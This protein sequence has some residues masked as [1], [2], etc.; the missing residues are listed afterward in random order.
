MSGASQ[1]ELQEDIGTVK[2]DIQQ[3]KQDLRAAKATG[4]EKAVAFQQKQ[5]G[6]LREKELVLL[7][8][9]VSFACY[10]HQPF[11]NKTKCS[12]TV[13]TTAETGCTGNAAFRLVE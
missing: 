3:A 9:Q 4:H 5:L 11:T 12:D 1:S 13:A 10:Y 8:A 7:R 6:Q 2:A